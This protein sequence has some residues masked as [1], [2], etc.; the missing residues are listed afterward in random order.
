MIMTRRLAQ[1]GTVIALLM[2]LLAQTVSAQDGERLREWRA[3][4]EARRE[5]AAQRRANGGGAK[6]QPNE[7]AMEGLPP[8]WVDRVRDMPPDQQQQFFENNAQFKQLPPARQAQVRQNLEKWNQLS[9]EEKDAVRQ[10]EQFLDNL[11]PE[12]REYVRNTLLPKW[13]AL[14]Q[15]RR[16][17]INQHLAMLRNMSPAT[18]QAALND[19]KFTQGLSA[20]EQSML[21]DLNSLRNPSP[22]AEPTPP[23]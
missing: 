12:Q 11:P 2:V 1:L 19:P 18:Q 22:S 15:P 7:R 3:R 10:R 5:A 4:Q 9:P 14:P 13:Q 21:R 16:Q 6:G 20:D 23:Q 17:A 8:K